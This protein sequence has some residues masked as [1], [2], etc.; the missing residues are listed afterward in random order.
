MIY[1]RILTIDDFDYMKSVSASEK[2]GGG[3]LLEL[4]HEIDFVNYLFGPIDIKYASVSQSGLL[5]I[6]VE[7]ISIG[8]GL[9][10]RS[11]SRF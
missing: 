10:K 4:S 2:L 3:V 5:K 8:I 7:D 1:L 11:G 6:D 9:D